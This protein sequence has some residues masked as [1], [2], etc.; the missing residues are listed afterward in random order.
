MTQQE[1][2]ELD[3][4]SAEEPAALQSPEEVE[5]SHFMD[6]AIILAKHR[7][8]VVVLP[9]VVGV[10]TAIVSL[11]LPPTYTADAKVVPPQQNQSMA[12]G[13]LGQLGPL[14]SAAANGKDDLRLHGPEDLYIAMLHSRTVADALIQRFSL[15]NVYKA[16]RHMDARAR[17]DA[18]TKIEISKEGVISIAVTDRDPKRSADMSN[19]YVE[20]L[21]KLTR[22]LAVTEAGQR[23]LFFEREVQ[24]AADELSNAEQGLKKAQEKSGI[25]QLDYQS[26]AMIELLGALHAQ[27]ASKEAQVQAMSGSIT[28]ENPDFVRAQQELAAVRTELA[29]VEAGQKGVSLSDLS[30]RKVPEAGLE[31][32]RRVR[33][34]KYRESLLELLTRQYEVARIDEAKNAP[35]VQV[36]D[37][38][39]PPE[40]R[41]WPHRSVLVLSAVFL[42]FSLG[43]ALAFLAEPFQR[44]RADPEFA[45]RVKLV[46]LYLKGG[47]SGSTAR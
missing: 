34:V 16:K 29:R 19:A 2:A 37:K 20:E 6:R 32:L 27:V 24:S 46:R 26:K 14:A 43:L 8:L 28:P 9:L 41:S 21:L 33:E 25:V 36:L 47:Q 11:L 44:M 17:L 31:Y 40:M 45:T 42:A 12:A 7:F 35:I 10:I 1:I 5:K 38:A 18:E 30:M 23:R 39:E 15:M 22:T 4:N 13:I 3:L